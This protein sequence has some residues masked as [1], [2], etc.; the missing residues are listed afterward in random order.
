MIKIG[1]GMQMEMNKDII[2]GGIELKWNLGTG[3]VLF[4]GEM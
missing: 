2:V 3:E 4:E 1:G